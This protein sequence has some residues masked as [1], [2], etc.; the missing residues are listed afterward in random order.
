MFVAILM[1]CIY[2][3]GG[4]F[5]T[6]LI[7]ACAVSYDLISTLYSLSTTYVSSDLYMRLYRPGR[8]WWSTSTRC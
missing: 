2:A 7:V 6:S 3:L 8:Q 5:K 4:R 1:T